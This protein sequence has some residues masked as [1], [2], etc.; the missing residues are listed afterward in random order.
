MGYV[1]PELIVDE[2]ERTVTQIT[3]K[4]I[5]QM[6]AA[7]A[8]STGRTSPTTAGPV[9][10]SRAISADPA[11]VRVELAWQILAASYVDG[12][13]KKPDHRARG[14]AQRRALPLRDLHLG[15]ALRRVEARRRSPNG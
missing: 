2:R 11:S 6:P 13:K 9:A 4:G 8:W 1:S 3:G 14:R 5:D 7:T 12:R 15:P 10:F